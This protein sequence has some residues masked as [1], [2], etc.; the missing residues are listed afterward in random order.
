M[1]SVEIRTLAS[2]NARHPMAIAICHKLH[3]YCDSSIKPKIAPGEIAANYIV[4]RRSRFDGGDGAL[5]NTSTPA[6]PALIATVTSR[7]ILIAP[8]GD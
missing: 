1:I 6:S 5:S 4:V 8:A 7:R 3:E 2:A